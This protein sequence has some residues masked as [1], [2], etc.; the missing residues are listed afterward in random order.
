M[1][2]STTTAKTISSCEIA[3]L[4][5]KSHD[6]VIRDIRKTLQDDGQDVLKF[7]GIYQDAYK[8]D[9]VCYHLPRFECDLVVSGYSVKYRAAIIRRWHE[10]EVAAAGPVLEESFKARVQVEESPALLAMALDGVAS[11][12][13]S[14]A[15]G[16]LALAMFDRLVGTGRPVENRAYGAKESN[17]VM[18][19]PVKAEEVWLEGFEDPLHQRFFIQAGLVLNSLLAGRRARKVTLGEFMERAVELG[20]LQWFVE[21]YDTA[22]GKLTGMGLALQ[23]CCGRVWPLDLRLMRVAKSNC[24][25]FLVTKGDA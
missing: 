8:R 15:A 22:K 3:Q 1:N 19:F 14:V 17:E 23:R 6:N 10:L 11:G 24:S 12:K 9:K 5:G 13:L 16:E 21:S 18:V 4:T 20:Q 2:L 25:A 7:E